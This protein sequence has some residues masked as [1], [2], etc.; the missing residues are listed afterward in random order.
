MRESNP[1]W[2]TEELLTS[3]KRRD[4]L[5]KIAS[6]SKYENDWLNFKQQR[7]FVVN[8][9]NRLKKQYFQNV[10]DE[11]K[12]D[13]K[14]LWKTLNSIIPNDKKSNTTT[15]FITHEGK[16]ITEKGKLLKLLTN[17]SQ[18]LETS[19]YFHFL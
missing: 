4:Y 1:Q 14:K 19:R 16:E 6:R 15:H 12:D 5:Q 10:I 2:V 18:L 7:N 8:L 3:I 11:S 17:F 9:K 13:S